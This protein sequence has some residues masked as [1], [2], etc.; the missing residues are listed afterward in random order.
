MAR[1]KPETSIS[2][3][4]AP[5]AARHLARARAYD[6]PIGPLRALPELELSII[7]LETGELSFA[8]V[9]RTAEHARGI[10]KDITSHGGWRAY[11]AASLS[12]GP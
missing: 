7:E 5:A 3:A 6:L 9:L 12:E 11:R 4:K 1:D 8:M 2:I 10:H